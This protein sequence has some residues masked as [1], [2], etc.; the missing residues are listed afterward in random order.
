MLR[1]NLQRMHRCPLSWALAVCLLPITNVGVAQDSVDLSHASRLITATSLSGGV[2]VMLEPVTAGVGLAVAKEGSFTVQLLQRRLLQRDEQRGAIRAAHL[3]ENVSVRLYDG[4]RLPYMDNLINLLIVDSFPDL[5]TGGLTVDEI[6]R[7]VAPLGDAW[8]G[9][10][11]SSDRR[12]PWLDTLRSAARSAGYEAVVADELEGTWLRITKPWPHEIDE[13]THFLHG[14]DG[15]PVAQDSVVGP[16]KHYQWTG[17]PIWLRSH[18]TDSSISTMVTAQGRLFY[19]VDEAPISLPGDHELPDKWFLVGRDAFNGVELWKVPIRRW[20]WREWKYSWFS[21]RPGD[22]PFDIRKR[23]VAVG[24]QVYVTLGYRARVSQLDARSGTLLQTYGE[25]EGA[26]ELLYHDGILFLSVHEG[27]RLAVMAIESQSGRTLWRTASKYLGS[28]T[29]YLLW[30]AAH[31][32]V[33]APRLSPA[34]NLATDGRTVA[35]IDGKQIVALDAGDGHEKWHATLPDHAED[36]YTGGIR[37]AGNLWNGTMIVS[38]GVVLHASPTALGAFSSD[39]GKV[40]WVQP[41]K[42]IQHLWYEWKDVF[43][44]DQLV[45]TWS[46]EFE[47]ALITLSNGS[48]QR[49]QWPKFVNGYDLQTGELKKQVAVGNIFRTYH[50]H[51]CYRNKATLRYILASRRGTEFVDLQQGEHT[52]DNWV[53]GTCH[54][55]MMPANGLQYVPPHPCQCYIAEK[56]VGMN[57]L[58]SRLQCDDIPVTD[59]QRLFRGPA[60]DAPASSEQDQAV[61]T[62]EQWPTFRH[63]AART[64]AVD[65]QLADDITLKWSQRLG[66]KLSSPTIAANRLFVAQIDQHYVICLDARDGTRLWEFAADAR[67]DSPPTYHQGYLLFG[68]HDGWVY[69]LRATDG[70]LVWKFLAAPCER[71]MAAFGQLESA[72]PVPGS[73]LV[74]HDTVYCTAGRSS[75]LDGGIYLYALDVAT[76][77]LLHQ[78][79]LDGPHYNVHNVQENYGLPTGALP[80][81]LVSDGDYLFMRSVAFDR[82]LQ[83]VTGKPAMQVDAGYLDDSYFKRT[84]WKMAPGGYGRLI[85]HDNQSAYYVRMFDSLRGLDPKVFFTPGQ[86]GYLLFASNLGK[87]RDSWRTR[88]PVRIKAM[89]LTRNRLLAA[90]PPDVVDPQDPLGAFEDREGGLLLSFDAQT[91]D[92][93]LQQK[94]PSPP[95]FNGVAAAQDALYVV[96]EQGAVSCYAP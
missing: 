72:W 29:D 25:T 49:Q 90:G 76:G 80:D 96:D 32:S 65:T 89:V 61:T 70:R 10:S 4:R 95:V 34:A 67:I 42:F 44:I 53:R 86:K 1:S 52:V 74:Q 26:S 50:H 24:D 73:V 43:V 21:T 48:K 2:C 13:W 40:L 78:T 3:S 75:E 14:A 38:G 8:I 19:I 20:G 28:T 22:Y 30:R 91:G 36:Q 88:V 18:E 56:L 35:L 62:G 77:E 39:T 47:Q 85:V 92:Q 31:G 83:Q 93:K 57:V 54:V 27:D 11:S 68:A 5:S 82:Q 84:P 37:A 16:P 15:N 71:L 87:R 9:S 79:R 58:A 69:C 17:G 81:I 7:V 66:G 33:R 41:K 59:E 46:A 60:Y 55:G 23:L 63:D 45:W 6:M 51:R 12:L 94:L 64:G